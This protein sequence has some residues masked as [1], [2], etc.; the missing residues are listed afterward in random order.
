MQAF[1]FFF[2][3]C[4]RQLTLNLQLSGHKLWALYVQTDSMH[5]VLLSCDVVLAKWLSTLC[6]IKHFQVWNKSSRQLL[7]SCVEKNSYYKFPLPKK[8]KK[9]RLVCFY[10]G[11]PRLGL[12]RNVTSHR[13]FAQWFSFFVTCL[14]VCK[15]IHEW[16]CHAQ[17][18]WHG[19]STGL[20]LS[21]I[22]NLC[23]S[24][25]KKV[26]FRCV[27]PNLQYFGTL[28]LGTAENS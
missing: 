8:K 7:F 2:P 10:V 14:V 15:A 5:P 22:C 9:K 4:S 19:V 20:V 18:N 3:H 6:T 26:T 25:T 28:Q 11:L 16:S 12:S 27:F 21:T 23:F 13:N 1:F 17:F 24:T